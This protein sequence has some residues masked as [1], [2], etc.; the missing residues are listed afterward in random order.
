MSWH[1]SCVVKVRNESEDPGRVLLIL[2]PLGSGSFNTSC[3]QGHRNL[4]HRCCGHCSA[5]EQSDRVK[6]TVEEEK[7]MDLCSGTTHSQNSKP[8]A[9][10]M[11]P[12]LAITCRTTTSRQR[13]EFR[14]S[15]DRTTLSFCTWSYRLCSSPLLSRGPSLPLHGPTDPSK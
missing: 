3:T 9:D 2:K 5:N 15:L 6:G 1:L 12:R 10:I 4:T 7:V 8:A 14:T 11:I 13:V